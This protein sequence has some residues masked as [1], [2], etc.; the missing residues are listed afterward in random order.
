MSFKFIHIADIHWRGLSR[1]EEYKRSFEDAFAKMRLENP[2]AIFVV[3]D[4]VHSKTQGIS[5]ELISHLAWW[6]GELNR[7]APTFITLG[8][9][10]GLI[11]NRDRQDAVSPI[12]NAMNL[13]NVR[14][15]K[16]AKNFEFKGI[17]FSNFCPFD[18][19]G[20]SSLQT[21]PEKLNIALFHGPLKGCA[22]EDDWNID[23]DWSVDIF[24]KYDFA[25][26]GDIHKRQSIDSAG[27]FLYCG[28]TIQQNYGE[29]PGKGFTVW[30]IDSGKK[31]AHRHVEVEHCSPFVTIDWHGTV[32]A[33][34]D[35]ASEFKDGSRFRVKTKSR[36]TQPEIKQ[37]H[38]LL[39]E[40]KYAAEIVY[41]I[42][43]DESLPTLIED[44]QSKLNLK[45]SRVITELLVDY[46]SK[47]GLKEESNK[48][49]EEKIRKYCESHP[50]LD[51][52]ATGKWSIKKMEFDNTFGYGKGNIINF[53]NL[54]GITGLFGQ[55][56]V[57]K[58]SVCGTL[59][60]SLFNT[61]DRGS[62][63]NL[64]II[65]SRKGYCNAITT[66][67]KGS[68]L[69]RVE[70]QTV[71]KETKKGEQSGVTSLNL[72]EIDQDGNP[73][74]D[75]CDEQRRETDKVLRDLIG[76][77][78]DFLL[79]GFAAQGEMNTFIEQKAAARK[80]ILTRFLELEV[81]DHIY[82]QA[83]SESVAIKSAL[84]LMPGKDY[85]TLILEETN[86]LR[87][88]EQIRISKNLSLEKIKKEIKEIEI[89]LAKSGSD[90]KYTPQELNAKNQELERV[91]S[92][93]EDYKQE[94]CR[95]EISI[96]ESESKIA[97][98]EDVRS[99][100][101]VEELKE[102]LKNYRGIEQQIIKI[103]HE[104]EKETQ[105]QKTLQKQ[106]EV[107]D[108]VPCGDQFPTCPFITNAHKAKTQ[109]RASIKKIEEISLEMESMKGSFKKGTIEDL[110]KKLE[111]YDAFILKL[112]ELKQENA[113]MQLK[114][115]D[116][117]NKCNLLQID[118]EN[119]NS[120]INEMKSNIS[121]DEAASILSGLRREL[122]KLR[123]EENEISKNIVRISESIGLSNSNIKRY[124]E[125]KLHY[126]ELN[127]NWKI[128]EALMQAS[129][130]N[131]V[132][133]AITRQRLPEINAEISS[134]LQT[135]AGFTVELD[136]PEGSNEME[137]YIN[138]GDSKRPIEGCSG[139]EKM[140]ASL[141][142]R[143]ALTNVSQLPKSDFFIIDEGF[144]A[145]DANNIESCNRFLESLKKW[146][147]C[148]LII[149]HIDA[150]KDV[151]D[152][153]IEIERVNGDARIK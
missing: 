38:S 80:N 6:F 110:E 112:N 35:A 103:K 131:G 57:G 58:S 143:V 67:S 7:I 109:L 43:I 63:P 34:V 8:N 98:I 13:P 62:M 87:S 29:T 55:N 122:N 20:W 24:D 153:V 128:Y 9:H 69:Y 108:D 130:K 142:I 93:L 126:E 32:E 48:V 107:L 49:I 132:P 150:V 119:C 25:F 33:T 60:Y 50:K 12:I 74:R 102:S 115:F 44:S 117:L 97:K 92:K 123:L 152:N 145:L 88:N 96:E 68:K 140:M 23:S 114:K 37:L 133:L 113:R 53:D 59:M 39:K 3:G 116:L 100:F 79:T 72:F 1:H 134:I 91:K 105:K 41:K 26:L 71:R 101:P 17:N 28:S 121:T 86:K 30:E 75:L 19:E 21:S 5:P 45:D 18:E 82:E 61:S 95:L 111:K 27:R 89:N 125:E 149:S 36:I 2:D 40:S 99:N 31:F 118:I 78:E 65:N 94:I 22:T 11:T 85:E 54:E 144:G 16:G 139:M 138:Y 66:I 42:E 129:S 64:H 81:F 106:V 147:R 15:I 141:A 137:I 151:V 83:K 70:R 135:S 146:F 77:S 148:I 90:A 124:E 14:L 73:I 52:T 136:S 4:V 47:M 104:S 127:D 56:R 46:C 84:K 10:D 76:S 51:S 120:V